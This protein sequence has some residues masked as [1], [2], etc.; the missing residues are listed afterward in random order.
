[1][2]EK[3]IENLLKLNNDER[4]DYFLRHCADF[5]EIWGLSV[6]EDEWVVFK[7]LDGKEIFPVWP[8][9]ALADRCCFKEHKEMGASP[10]LISFD[11][12]IERCIPDMLEKNIFFGVFFNLNKE[13]NLLDPSALKE[14]LEEEHESLYG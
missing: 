7:D 10:Q 11:D 9:A 13:A 5:E 2:H 12:F 14:K 3:K 1:M 8:E 4:L 6:S